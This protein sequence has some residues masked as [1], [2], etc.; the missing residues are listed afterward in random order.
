MPLHQCQVKMEIWWTMDWWPGEQMGRWEMNDS[1]AG[2]KDA[3]K[4]EETSLRRRPN[5]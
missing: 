1:A 4:L 3:L 2:A 5:F